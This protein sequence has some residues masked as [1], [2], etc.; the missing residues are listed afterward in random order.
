M[1]DLR[2]LP[3]WAALGALIGLTLGRCTASAANVPVA[4]QAS[5]LRIGV[6]DTGLNTYTRTRIPLCRDWAQDV[7]GTGTQDD[8]ESQHGSNVAHI[9]AQEAGTVKFCLVIIKVFTGPDTEHNKYYL[10]GLE[11]A[12]TLK[13]DYLNASMAGHGFIM[14][15]RDL[16]RR[17]LDRGTRIVASAGNDEAYLGHTC[18]LYPACS[19]PRVIV[20]GAL[21]TRMS[22]R[23]PRITAWA[24]GAHVCGGGVCLTGT[25]QATAAITGRLVREQVESTTK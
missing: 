10:A 18:Y 14:R 22:N 15:E 3:F 16:I 4:V 1:K 8:N 2:L 19:D 17:L 20:V 21:G 12:L 5:V 13:L 24:N 11:R 7:T 25:S 9:I 6:L 23:G